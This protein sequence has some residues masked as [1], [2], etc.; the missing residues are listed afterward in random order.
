MFG[1]SIVW[2]YVLFNRIREN[3]CKVLKMLFLKN[4]FADTTM[5]E[6]MMMKR[7]VARQIV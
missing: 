1:H 7:G 5:D 3:I 4:M 6:I 2:D